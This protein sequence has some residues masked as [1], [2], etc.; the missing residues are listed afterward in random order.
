MLLELS[1][2]VAAATS[3]K[4]AVADAKPIRTVVY[5][6]SYSRREELTIGHFGG[7]A[8]MTSTDSAVSGPVGPGGQVT[9]TSDVGTITVDV[10]AVMKGTV[11]A[12]IT[13]HWN[14]KSAPNVFKG[15]VNAD[16]SLIGYPPEMNAVARA[17]LPAF[18]T[19]FSPEGVDLS[20]V[21]TT[22]RSIA[23]PPEYDMETT[24]S[25]KRIDGEVVTL[26]E[27][28]TARS[29]SPHAPDTTETGTIAYKPK[30]LAPISGDL[31]MRALKSDE[32]SADEI[33]L[34]LHFTRASDTF[35][36]AGA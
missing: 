3:P 13:E 27:T 15:A 25:V 5:D 22:W 8:P 28:L 4:Q 16:G 33:N 36:R 10:Y 24:F 31:H 21:G 30:I 19:H 26:N 20:S 1:L 29:K 17:L 18:G 6:V 23:T 35:D 32:N 2:I 14:G 34:N 12:V 7:G 9:N 11:V